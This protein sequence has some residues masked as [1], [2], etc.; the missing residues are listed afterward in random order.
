MD[1]RFGG[2]E[3][4][5]NEGELII[6]GTATAFV[7][8]CVSMKPD[9]STGVIDRTEIKSAHP[10]IGEI[11]P[12]AVCEAIDAA[13]STRREVRQREQ[14]AGGMVSVAKLEGQT[15]TFPVP[16]YVEQDKAAAPVEPPLPAREPEPAAGAAV[17][18]SATSAGAAE[19]TPAL[20]VAD[21]PA[22]L[23]AGEVESAATPAKAPQQNA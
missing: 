21:S 2:I 14:T 16:L 5:E 19:A 8:V 20:P 17:E 12:K 6:R 3:P 4:G 9:G 13:F 15:I 1:F 22:P 23:R 7:R 18:A 11:L 10:Q